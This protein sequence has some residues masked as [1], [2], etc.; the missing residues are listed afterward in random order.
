LGPIGRIRR[1]SNGAQNCFPEDAFNLTIPI[2]EMLTGSADA[3]V[4]TPLI[5][6]GAGGCVDSATRWIWTCAGEE[7]SARRRSI[8][9]S[10]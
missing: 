6:C 4:M 8:A 3:F 1:R 7:G 5:A 2:P 10:T 9:G